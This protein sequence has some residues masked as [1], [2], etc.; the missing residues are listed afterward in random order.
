MQKAIVVVSKDK[1][2]KEWELKSGKMEM[3]FSFN[4]DSLEDMGDFVGLLKE[5]LKITQAQFNERSKR[6]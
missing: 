5:A 3:N 1:N 4:V 6:A 2:I